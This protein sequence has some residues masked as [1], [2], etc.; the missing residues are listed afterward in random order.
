MS[1]LGRYYL[2]GKK[3]TS[4]EVPE[5]ERTLLSDLTKQADKV[6]AQFFDKW[7]IINE[8][9]EPFSKSKEDTLYFKTQG[10]VK[11][12][13]PVTLLSPHSHVTSQTYISFNLFLS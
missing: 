11:N 3:S 10:W 8:K 9:S 4:W 1:L 6:L 13:D 12:G 2:I 5:Q 7:F